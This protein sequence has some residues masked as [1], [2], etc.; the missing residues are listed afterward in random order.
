MP[1]KP[2][3]THTPI[4]FFSVEPAQNDSIGTP[5]PFAAGKV[6]LVCWN[7]ILCEVYPVHSIYE[8]IHSHSLPPASGRAGMTMNT[9]NV[10]NKRK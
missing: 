7:D 5:E 9:K 8:Y 1:Y 6:G 10:L 3:L 2:P 4:L